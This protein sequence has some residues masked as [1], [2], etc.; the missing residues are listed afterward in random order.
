MKR[1]CFLVV[2]LLLSGIT[3]FG[4]AS[5]S[6]EIKKTID[7]GWG[8]GKKD[9]YWKRQFT[10]QIEFDHLPE[11]N[12]TTKVIVKIKSKYQIKDTPGFGIS[13]FEQSVDYTQL[14]PEWTL[15]I[16]PEDVYEG[17]FTITPREIGTFSLYLRAWGEPFRRTSHQ[18]FRICFT[19]DE[20]GKTIHLSNIPDYDYEKNGPPSHPPIMG[21]QVS[22]RYPVGRDFEN[23]FRIV[24]PLS[25]NDTST[26]YMELKSHRY[27]P[28]GVQLFL[29]LSPNLDVITLPSSWVGEVKEGDV[30][31]DSFKIVPKTTE[32]AFLYLNVAGNSPSEKVSVSHRQIAADTFILQFSFDSSGKLDYVGREDKYY[33]PGIKQP[34]EVAASLGQEYRRAEGELKEFMSKPKIPLRK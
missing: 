2:F 11:L 9:S 21:D 19:I 33:R 17:S 14:E 1:K 18:A 29:T 27:C 6:R 8:L 20:S 13:E 16:S 10:A 23:S 5:Q 34:A 26:I 12:K 24:P 4:S 32:L 30:Y 25:L 31:Q 22:I 3:F 15:P 7:Y 28:K